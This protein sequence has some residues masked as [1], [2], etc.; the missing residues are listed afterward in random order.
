MI[1]NKLFAISRINEI[2][3]CV[4]C[5]HFVSFCW[6]RIDQRDG[7]ELIE[8]GYEMSEPGYDS[9]G[10]ENPWVRNNFYPSIPVTTNSSFQNYPHPRLRAVSLFLAFSLR[11]LVVSGSGERRSARGEEKPLPIPSSFLSLI[12]IISTEFRARGGFQGQ[13]PTT[14]SLPSPGRSHYTNNKY[15]EA[16]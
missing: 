7:Y 14:R 11:F 12:C 4:C 13:K 3:V 2:N 8:S 1:R 6:V 15:I 10:Y 16:S 9:S 5:K